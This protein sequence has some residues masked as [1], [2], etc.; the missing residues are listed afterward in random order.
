MISLQ[1]ISFKVREYEGKW[2]G[3]QS[4]SLSKQLLFVVGH[5]AKISQVLNY[6]MK[7]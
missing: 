1:S 4:Y 3:G 2:R 7:N 5:C 6:N